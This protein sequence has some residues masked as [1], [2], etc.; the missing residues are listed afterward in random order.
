MHLHVAVVFDAGDRPILQPFGD[1]RPHL[2]IGQGIAYGFVLR[3]LDGANAV[4][5]VADR[6][7]LGCGE[8][9]FPLGVVDVAPG[10]ADG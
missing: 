3:D 1:R 9:A 4:E 8:H 10:G 6:V 5:H 7:G 2:G